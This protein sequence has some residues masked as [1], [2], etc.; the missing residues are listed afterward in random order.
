MSAGL[1]SDGAA[2]R[3]SL[4]IIYLERRKP[5]LSNELY[6]KRAAATRRLK[7]RPPTYKDARQSKT[8]AEAT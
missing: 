4:S 1:A 8:G 6:R 5:F 7:S 3:I 2:R